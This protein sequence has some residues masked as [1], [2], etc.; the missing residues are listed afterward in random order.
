MQTQK[1][2]NDPHISIRACEC[3]FHH[4]QPIP[5]FKILLDINF[6]WNRRPLTIWRF[7]WQPFW[8]WW[9]RKNDPEWKCYHYQPIP[10]FKILLD[11]NFHWIRRA[12]TICRFC[13]RPFWKRWHRKNDP[14]CNFHHYQ[15]IPHFKIT[16]DIN[17]PWKQRILKFCRFCLRPLECNFQNTPRYQFSLKLEYIEILPIFSAAISK[18]K[19]TLN[20][21]FIFTNQFLT[22]K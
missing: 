14:E 8:K 3:K 10:L 15:S 9:A 2:P 1:S 19:M 18:I 12:L 11:I 5:H 16:L 13:W 6:H 17:F 22:S 21:I 4:Y 20:A 7:C